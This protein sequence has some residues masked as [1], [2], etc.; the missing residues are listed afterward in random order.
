VK[1]VVSDL[2]GREVTVLS[3]GYSGAGKHVEVFNGAHNPSG[4]YFYTIITPE[5]KITKKMLMLK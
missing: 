2:L 3:E 1:L 4:I 5:S